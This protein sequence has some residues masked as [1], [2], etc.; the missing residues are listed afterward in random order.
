MD[1]DGVATAKLRQNPK[2][3]N[4]ACGLACRL[5]SKKSSREPLETTHP[6]APPNALQTVVRSGRGGTHRQVSQERTHT[7]TRTHTHKHT[8]NTQHTHTHTHT[9][10]HAHTHTRARPPAQIAPSAGSTGNKKEYSRNTSGQTALNRTK[11]QADGGF[12]EHKRTS[13]HK[14]TQ[15]QRTSLRHEKRRAAR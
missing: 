2:A 4:A 12:H 1:V 10:T 15:D 11:L 9:H 14:P 13:A 7:H 5:F 8:H 3:W 6:H